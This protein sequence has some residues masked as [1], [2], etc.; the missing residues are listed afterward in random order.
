MN[1]AKNCIV[2]FINT[3][4]VPITKTLVSAILGNESY[5]LFTCCISM[6][7]ALSHNF[8]AVGSNLRPWLMTCKAYTLG[9]SGDTC[10]ISHRSIN[11]LKL[12]QYSITALLDIIVT[13]DCSIKV[14]IIHL[15]YLLESIDL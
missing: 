12:F 1:S 2:A 8:K 14:F 6:P 13:Y 11:T 15:S 10:M 5:L 9:R 7:I 4:Y 3:V